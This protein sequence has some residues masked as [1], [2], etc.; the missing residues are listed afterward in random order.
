M[1]HAYLVM[2]HEQI[3]LL[4][5][6]FRLLAHPNNDIFLHVDKKTRIGLSALQGM[7]FYARPSRLFLTKRL[8]VSWGGASQTKAEMLLYKAARKHG[9]Y[10]FYHLM[11]G[12]DLPIKSQ[13]YIQQFFEKPENR[14]TIFLTVNPTF[15]DW[16]FERL[17]LYHFQ[18]IL[19]RYLNAKLLDLQRK[20]GINRLKHYDL[21]RRG[22]NWCSLP[23]YAVDFL[24]EKG[25]EIR[26]MVEFSKNSDEVYK[27]LIFINEPAFR[28]KIAKFSYSEKFSLWY[29]LWEASTCDHPKVLNMDDYE[30]LKRTPSLFARKFSSKDEELLLKVTELVLGDKK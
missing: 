19:P 21:F 28:D 29:I 2:A 16:D 17:S 15:S 1:K 9:A 26:R 6:Q 3:E 20:I 5:T 24:L 10:D 4:K 14:D 22:W 11:S 12:Y 25:R 18:N 13:D 8:D 27:Q 7:E 30:S 23:G